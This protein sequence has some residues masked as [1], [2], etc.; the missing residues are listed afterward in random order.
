MV[1]EWLSTKVENVDFEKMNERIN[2]IQELAQNATKL[3]EA[4]KE[5]EEK[6]ENGD[7]DD[8]EL[9]LIDPNDP[10]SAKSPGK[11]GKLRGGQRDTGYDSEEERKK[12]EK[13]K[14]IEQSI[15]D[16]Q[17]TIEKL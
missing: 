7:D 3:A 5:E 15:T 12:E 17:E 16:M 9:E 1:K 4:K 13:M 8:A 10:E 14:A 11:S 6:E 2:E